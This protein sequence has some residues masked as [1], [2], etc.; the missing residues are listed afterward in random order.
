MIESLDSHN[1]MNERSEMAEDVQ[2]L[3]TPVKIYK[4]FIK[5]MSFVGYV[6]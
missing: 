3:Q 6:D 4:D 5:L 1:H 2:L